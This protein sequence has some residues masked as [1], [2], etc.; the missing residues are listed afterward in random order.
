MPNVAE[1]LKVSFN[2]R[3]KEFEDLSEFAR[4]RGTSFTQTLREAVSVASFLREAVKS[5]N[6]ILIQPGSSRNCTNKCVPEKTM[7]RLGLVDHYH[8][9][10][11]P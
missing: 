3:L 6:R 8:R 1:R 4:L 11:L 2:L 10:E 9:V 7:N 5:G